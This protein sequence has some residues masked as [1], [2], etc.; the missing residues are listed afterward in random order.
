M[1]VGFGPLLAL[2]LAAGLL[3]GIAFGGGVLYGRS[4]APA[5]QAQ[6]TSSSGGGA[7]AAGGGAGGAGGGGGAAARGSGTPGAGGRGGGGGAGGG[8]G[9]G[10]VQGSITA[11]NG[12]TLTVTTAGGTTQRVT[13]TGQ[14]QVSA[15]T[16]ASQSD[17]VPGSVVLVQGQ[18]GSGGDITAGSITI[19][20]VSPSLGAAPR[21]AGTPATGSRRGGTPTPTPTP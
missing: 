13:L 8:A 18:A 3:A 1:K 15:V 11:I 20:T 21:A 6:T 4:N 12:N 17:L 2:A 14:T 19:T 10:L 7:A 16:P 5:A 9:G